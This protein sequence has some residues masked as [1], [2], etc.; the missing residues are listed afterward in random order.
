M[1]KKSS[2]EIL[3][4]MIG[5]LLLYIDEL[6]E[7]KDAENEMFQYGERTAYT[8]CLEWIQLWQY[9]EANGLDYNIEER[10]PL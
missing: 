9:A 2:E 5:L 3:E 1:Q 4:M 10:Y 7:N 8:E 6:F